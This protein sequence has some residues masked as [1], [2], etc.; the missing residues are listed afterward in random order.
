MNTIQ[1][2]EEYLVKQIDKLDFVIDDVLFLMPDS[3]FYPPEIHQEELSAIRDQLNTL[4]R[5]KNFPAYRHDRNIDYQYN[6]LLKKYEAS[7]SA[8]AVKK[9]S[10]LREE[11]LVETDEMKCACMISLIKEYNL[12]G[13]LRAYE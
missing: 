1:L 9:R 8:L 12:L 2:I 3:Y 6:K 4:I 10:Q 11:L 7:L 5:K 13:R